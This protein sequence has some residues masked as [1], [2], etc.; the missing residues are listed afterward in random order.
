MLKHRLRHVRYWDVWLLRCLIGI[1]SGPL[2]FINRSHSIWRYRPRPSKWIRIL[3]EWSHSVPDD[4]TLDSFID[5]VLKILIRP[6]RSLG[7]TYEPWFNSWI[8]RNQWYLLVVIC[9]GEVLLLYESVVGCD[10]SW[11]RSM[12]LLIAPMALFLVPILRS[13]IGLLKTDVW[14]RLILILRKVIR[15]SL[16]FSFVINWLKVFKLALI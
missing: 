8:S 5:L 2:F 13:I 7:V 15:Y 11:Q 4:S 9:K 6:L 3:R 16:S 12:V 10:I 14:W 1:Y